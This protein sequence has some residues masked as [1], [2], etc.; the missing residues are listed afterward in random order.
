[1]IELEV[2]EQ[3]QNI[4]ISNVTASEDVEGCHRQ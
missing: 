1:M 4:T 3:S 2:G